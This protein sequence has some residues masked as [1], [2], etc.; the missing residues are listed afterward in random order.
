MAMS[1]TSLLGAPR[2]LG[3][4]GPEPG[5]ECPAC[6]RR[7]PHPAKPGS[8]R[9]RPL[10]YR[11]PEDERKAHEEIMAEAGKFLGVFQTPFWQFKV[12]ALAVAHLLQDEK[13]EGFG[14]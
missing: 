6:H 2:Q 9:S 5:E 8:P 12:T 13:L 10:S 14:Q 7:V 3:P 11:V 1:W 4:A